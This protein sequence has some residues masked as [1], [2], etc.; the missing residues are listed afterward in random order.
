MY[1]CVSGLISDTRG[2]RETEGE[3]IVADGGRFSHRVCGKEK[4]GEEGGWSM[5][6]AYS[7]FSFCVIPSPNH[8]AKTTTTTKRGA[9]T[10][11]HTQTTHTHTNNT[12]SHTHMLI[13]HE[14]GPHLPRIQT[15]P[16]NSAGNR[17]H[18]TICHGRRWPKGARGGDCVARPIHCSSTALCGQW[19]SKRGLWRGHNKGRVTG[20]R[21]KCVTRRFSI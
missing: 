9:Q 5:K 17:Q 2:E 19:C 11:T 8:K 16:K 18:R 15:E 3:T 12:H 4:R 14:S 1:S 7:D 20:N 13:M 10:N 21:V 6:C